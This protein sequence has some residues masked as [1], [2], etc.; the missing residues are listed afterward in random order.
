MATLPLDRAR[1][2]GLAHLLLLLPPESTR[3]RMPKT[4]GTGRD[5]SA[6]ARVPPPAPLPSVTVA[7][8]SATPKSSPM[9]R[10]KQTLSPTWIP[11]P[12]KRCK[13]HSR[14][15]RLVLNNAYM[16]CVPR[17]PL[18]PALSALL[19]AIPPPPALLLPLL[20]PN[21]AARLRTALLLCLPLP[22]PPLHLL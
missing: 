10:L 8:R 3:N 6:S 20:R 19:P 18:R 1:A 2:L 22:P 9:Q 13:P 7:N 17:P 4:Q 21:G 11:A 16:S 15:F 5:T 12:A 14:I